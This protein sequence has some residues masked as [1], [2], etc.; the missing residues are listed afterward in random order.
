MEVAIAARR[1]EK[2]DE[3]ERLQKQKEMIC[4]AE[5]KEKVCEIWY[6]NE[7]LC[8]IASKISNSSQF[9]TLFVNS[10]WY[11]CRDI[12]LNGALPMPI[13]ALKLRALPQ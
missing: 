7:L 11:L 6:L 9:F 4:R 5:E 12:V 2:E 10:L 1:K 8:L 3:K 13:L